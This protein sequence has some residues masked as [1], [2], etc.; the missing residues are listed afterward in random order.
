MRFVLRSSCA[1][2]ICFGKILNHCERVRTEGVVEVEGKRG[3]TSVAGGLRPGP[4]SAPWKYSD[5]FARLC[6][7]FRVFLKKSSGEEAIYPSPRVRTRTSR[8]NSLSMYLTRGVELDRSIVHFFSR[9]LLGVTRKWNTR[10]LVW[11]SNWNQRS[12]KLII[13]L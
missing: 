13:K 1:R 4:L 8:Q 7:S 2:L 10:G 5:V 3:Q 11:R 6:R 9:E 12:V